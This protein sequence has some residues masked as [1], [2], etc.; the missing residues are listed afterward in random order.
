MSA[1][2]VSLPTNTTEETVDFLRR[3]ASM[4]SGGRNG[5][6]LLQAASMI[7]QLS[8]RAT[9][10]EQLYHQQQEEST[11]NVELRDV[12]ELA[13]DRLLAE[14]DTLKAQLLASTRQAE[15]ER[16]QFAGEARRLVALAQDAEA[17]LAELNAELAELRQPAEPQAAT[18]AAV[19]TVPVSSLELART[20]FRYL[21]DGFAKNGDVISQTICEIGRCALDQALESAAA[22]EG[23]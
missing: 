13:G 9:S 15:I 2:V 22:E 8:R 18:E 23:R 11:R 5:E 14:V 10:A 1:T 12:A 6:M 3:L 7:E 19:V 21:A 16:T 17:R 4:L 20:Q